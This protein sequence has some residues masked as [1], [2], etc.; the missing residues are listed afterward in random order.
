MNNFNPMLDYQRN[1]LLAQQALIQNQLSQMNHNQNQIQ[2]SPYPQTNQPQF[3][4]RQVGSVDEAKSF[5]VDPNTMYFFPDTGNGKIYVKQLN[6]NNGKSDF[7]TYSVQEQTEEKKIDPIEEINNRLS[8][9]ENIIGGIYDKSISND[10]S[11]KK[12]N[13]DDSATNVRKNEKSK[14]SDVSASSTN[15]SGKEWNTIKRNGS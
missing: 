15:D 12:S 3:F 13:G 9:I 1:Q 6:V 11:S 10:A 7:F 8:N 4:V 2:F 5:P 14:S